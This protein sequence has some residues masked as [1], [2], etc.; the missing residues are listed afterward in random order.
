MTRTGAR[1]GTAVLAVVLT[2]GAAPA[3][4]AFP[5]TV[6]G[7]H[8]D[9]GAGDYPLQGHYSISVLEKALATLST[10]DVEYTI[11]KDALE[12]AIHAAEAQ[13]KHGSTGGSTTTPHTTTNDNNPGSGSTGNQHTS[14]TTPNGSSGGTGPISSQQIDAAVKNG[15]QPQDLGGVVYTP[16][17]ITT[18]DSSFLGSI[19]DPVLGVLAALIVGL[20]VLGGWYL[21]NV[22]RARRTG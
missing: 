13:T 8:A 21:R 5:N 16:G 15:Q 10:S 14:G 19:P 9:C 22:V 6:A 18:H 11:C 4:G 1:L 2:L 17:A 3:F 20:G 7:A 12:A